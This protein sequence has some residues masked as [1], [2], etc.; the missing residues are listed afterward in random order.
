MVVLSAL[1]VLCMAF[2]VFSAFS[3]LSNDLAGYK[4]L[5]MLGLI[6]FSLFAYLILYHTWNQKYL[7]QQ[8]RLFQNS[9]INWYTFFM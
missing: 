7:L 6:L 3:V 8:L 2:V 5:L 9:H 4:L 1:I